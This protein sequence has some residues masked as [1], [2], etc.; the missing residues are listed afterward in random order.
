[1][2]S[3]SVVFFRAW[4]ARPFQIAAVVPSGRALAGIMTR[5]ITPQTGH[6]IELGPGTGVFTSKM[7]DRGVKPEDMTLVEY[8]EEFAGRLNDRFPR[9]RILSMDAA[10]IRDLEFPPEASVGAVVSGLPLLTMPARKVMDILGGAFRHLR[11]GGAFYQFTYMSKCP[12]PQSVLDHL[13][14]SATLVDRTFR[15]LPPAAVYRVTARR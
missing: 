9:A 3:D 14:L 1:M 11:P 4:V 5:E 13:D 8:S 10:R 6:V 15:N 12:V 2:Q 7:I